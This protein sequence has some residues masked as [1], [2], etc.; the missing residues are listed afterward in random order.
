MGV[1]HRAHPP[2]CNTGDGQEWD[3]P[4][5]FS[6]AKMTRVPAAQELRHKVYEGKFRRDVVSDIER[7]GHTR[8]LG[9]GVEFGCARSKSYFVYITEFDSVKEPN[10]RRVR[11]TTQVPDPFPSR[12]RLKDLA[13]FGCR[14][15]LFT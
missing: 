4:W 15:N 11:K 7:M 12:F 9:N 14:A 2:A 1:P 13:F 3:L 10:R 5:H 8:T 6:G